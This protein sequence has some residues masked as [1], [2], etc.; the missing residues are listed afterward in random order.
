MKKIFVTMIM[1]LVA[2]VTM[3]AQQT[4]VKNKELDTFTTV[5]VGGKFSFTL[6]TA[7][8]HSV[9]IT[10]DERIADYVRPVV[11]SGTFSIVLDE[12]KYPADLK[13]ALK[14]KGAKEPVLEVEIS[15]PYISELEV[16]EKAQLLEAD[17]I[18]VD[19]FTLTT[20][21]SAKVNG[22][23]VSCVRGE[24]N[25]S[26]SSS[27]NVTVDVDTKL[28]INSENSSSN[29][30]TQR[31][32]NSLVKSKGSSDLSL[33]T[34]VVDIDI[35]SALASN[36]YLSGSASALNVEAT[37]GSLIDAE[38]LEVKEGNFVQSGLSK[39]HVNVAERMKVN[40][41]GGTT[42]TFKRSPLIEVDRIVN[43]TLIKA[44]D[45]KRK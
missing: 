7:P 42:L 13:K 41:T 24:L 12:K 14:A 33:K 43:S 38:A 26:G 44:D 17:H 40:L 32:G 10:V 29:V 6:K 25:F 39:C 8:R 1:A 27:S 15:A 18:K 45:P 21:G 11:K 36:I 31:G 37:G 19:K 9:R 20:S 23:N 34:E 30:V 35:E 3:S 22:L 5:K 4:V 2:M 28:E 16:K